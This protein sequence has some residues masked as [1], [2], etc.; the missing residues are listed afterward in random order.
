MESVH[1]D[2]SRGSDKVLLKPHN[3]WDRKRGGQRE[4]V[5]PVN[6]NFEKGNQPRNSSQKRQRGLEDGEDEEIYS[7]K[8]LVGDSRSRNF[9]NQGT[10][11]SDSIKVKSPESRGKVKALDGSLVN[12]SENTASTIPQLSQIFPATPRDPQ[13]IQKIEGLNAKARASDGLPKAPYVPCREEQKKDT[14]LQSADSSVPA[15]SRRASHGAQGRLDHRGKRFHTLDADE[16]RK[17]TLAIGSIGEVSAANS[18]PGFSKLEK[19]PSCGPIQQW[20]EESG[21]PADPEVVASSSETAS[22]ALVSYPNAQVIESTIGVVESTVLSEDALLGTMHNVHSESVVSHGQALPLQRVAH[23]DGATDLKAAPQITEGSLSKHKCTGYK[24]K[25][26]ISMGKNLTEISVA[27]SPTEVPKE[28]TDAAVN[29]VALTEVVTGEV[30]PRLSK[31]ANAATV[32]TESGQPKASELELDPSAVQSRTVSKHAVQPSEQHPSLPVEEAG[33]RV[34]NQWKSQNA[35]RMQRNQQAH[36]N[37]EK[38]QSSDAGV[39]APVRSQDNTEEVDKA[40]KRTV[41]ETVTAT[42]KSENVVQNNIKNKRAEMER[43]V[44]KAV[45]KELAQQETVI[46]GSTAGIRNEDDKKT[47]QSKTKFMASE[48][49][50][51]TEQYQS[52]KPDV[53]SLKEQ[54]KSS[55]DWNNFD[56]WNTPDNCETAV[57]V[58]SSVVKN[59]E[60]TGKGKQIHLRVIQGRGIIISL[61]TGMLVVRTDKTSRQPLAPEIGQTDKTIASK[62]NRGVEE[63]TTHWKPKS[64]VHLVHNQLGN[65]VS[66]G[67]NVTAEASNAIKKHP[68]PSHSQGRVHLPPQHNNENRVKM[69]QSPIDQSV[70]EQKKVA[71]APNIKHQESKRERRGDSFRGHPYSPKQNNPSSRGHDP[72]GDWS[73]AGQDNRQHN[74]ASSHRGSQ[75]YNSQYECQPIGQFNNNKSN[76]FE[77]PTYG[78]HNTGSRYRERSQGHSR[79]GGGNF[80]GRQIGTVRVDAS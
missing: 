45:A 68:P 8:M 53:N 75:R 50:G 43:Y 59:Q 18:E 74:N 41:P 51:S 56:G 34:N 42:A 6:D 54:T 57:P 64:R 52:L 39:W 7:G 16:W 79:R 9:A 29:N 61:I 20:Q 23:T 62:E 36:R 11:S 47:K 78:P 73:S 22:S 32:S 25:K 60:V 5:I 28:Q 15:I 71:E 21:R 17:R 30:G 38:I 24:Q 80:Y 77:G 37:T 76:N 26:N 70:S 55:D 14:T 4:H 19:A 58:T 31:E 66:G 2:D 33:G 35:R 3:E 40:G 13:L 65:G 63:R 48:G 72:R 10:C 1:S 27:I 12:K 69:V 49:F 44:S 67:L 46:M